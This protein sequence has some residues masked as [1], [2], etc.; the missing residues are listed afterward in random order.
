[1]RI[2]EVGWVVF[3]AGL[4][5]AHFVRHDLD[6]WSAHTWW[7]QGWILVL[8]GIACALGLR[9]G[10]NRPL[11]WWLGWVGLSAWQLW[12]T[13]MVTQKVFPSAILLGLIHV[14]F[15]VLFYQAVMTYW[16]TTTVQQVC[17]AMAL[18][19]MVILVYGLL[20]L[21]SLDQ[22]YQNL[23][24]SPKDVL[25]G[26]MG[27]PSHFGSYLAFVLPL[28]LLQREWWWW[29]VRAV[30]LGL[31][32]VAN[33][34]GAWVSAMTVL[35]WCGWFWYRTLWKWLLAVI[36][37]GSLG[38]WVLHPGNVLNPYGRL[39]AWS[40]FWKIFATGKPITGMG[41][42]FIREL[43]MQSKHGS[44]L[45]QWHHV[46]LEWFQIAIEQGIIG[47]GLV[48]WIVIDWMRTVWKLPKSREVVALSGVGI[49]FLLNSCVNFPMHLWLL[50]SFG[51]LAY[52]G[53]HVLAREATA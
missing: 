10:S 39:E 41:I 20:Q 23:D 52:C 36:L 4:P 46:H 6:M 38:L 1:M 37:L 26:T 2:R 53:I 42:G 35:L 27:N 22:F 8:W 44:P 9:T 15:I 50:G 48:G 51:L 16:T 31:L 5:F 14:L 11:A 12:H 3:L 49:A 33:S 25:V 40:A 24:R 28:L 21:G 45:F 18:V 34:V 32:L 19:G 17:R 29:P 7:A 43:A 30:A 47:L 13:I